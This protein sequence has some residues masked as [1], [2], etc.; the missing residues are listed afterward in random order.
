MNTITVSALKY[1]WTQILIVVLYYGAISLPV[2]LFEFG[3]SY[4]EGNYHPITIALCSFGL[5]LL[6]FCL[7][8]GAKMPIRVIFYDSKFEIEERFLFWKST[9][10]YLYEDSFVEDDK[11]RRVVSLHYGNEIIRFDPLLWPSVLRSDLIQA[12]ELHHVE[13]HA[14]NV[15]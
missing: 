12:F 10:E 5:Y 1:W 13:V 15:R 7:F 8:Q 4:G 9:K 6:S 11:G 14:N 3:R 2:C